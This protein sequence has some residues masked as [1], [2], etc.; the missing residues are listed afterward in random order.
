MNAANIEL[1]KG[2]QFKV[3]NIGDSETPRTTAKL[4]MCA[5]AQVRSRA[6][7]H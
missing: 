1:F 4:E 2:H 5:G 6:G 7:A 3:I